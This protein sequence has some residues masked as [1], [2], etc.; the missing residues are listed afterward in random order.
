MNPRP[1]NLFSFFKE[2]IPLKLQMQMSLK[3]LLLQLL[4]F[5]A[6]K[7]IL[8][9]IRNSLLNQKF[10]FVV[11]RQTLNNNILQCKNTSE[12]SF[13]FFVLLDE[14]CCEII[15]HVTLLMIRAYGFFSATR[16]MSRDK[17]L[18]LRKMISCLGV[19]RK[20]RYI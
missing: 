16:I 5:F 11:L 7:N 13:V 10:N 18:R 6:K 2:Q 9:L 20:T 4:E 19:F 3:L 8:L 12:Y 15:D 14:L 1:K 17:Q